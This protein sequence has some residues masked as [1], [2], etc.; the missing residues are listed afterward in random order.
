MSKFLNGKTFNYE[1]R[2]RILNRKEQFR[3]RAVSL[4]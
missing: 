4:G 1:C 3:H 2:W